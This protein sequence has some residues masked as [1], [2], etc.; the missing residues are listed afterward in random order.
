[1]LI[2]APKAPWSSEETRMR[3]S[4]VS[5][6]RTPSG[7]LLPGSHRGLPPER[8]RRGGR[9]THTTWTMQKGASYN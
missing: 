1:M 7:T 6:E 5:E 3:R 9:P 2:S 4:G 8:E